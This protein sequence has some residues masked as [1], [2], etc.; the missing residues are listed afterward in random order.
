MS[1]A[2][3]NGTQTVINATTT[4]VTY[5]GTTTGAGTGGSVSPLKG[6][7]SFDNIQF[8]AT[9]GWIT[10]K[11]NGLI[12]SKIQQ[13]ANKTVLGNN[14]IVTNNVTAVSFTTVVDQ[15]GSVKKTQY[16]STGLLR[17]TN[18]AT[19]GYTSDSD[20]VMIE[21]TSGATGYSTGD[22]DKLMV[23]SSAGDFGGRTLTVQDLKLK[24][25]TDTVAVATLQRTTTA[26][27]GAHRVYN[28]NGSGGISLGSG[29]SGAGGVGLAA[30]HTTFYD[31]DYHSFRKRDGNTAAPITADSIQVTTITSGGPTTNASIIGRWSL[32]GVGSRM[33]ATYSADLAEYYEGDKTYEVGTVLIFGG[34]K[35][36]TIATTKEDYRIAGVVSDTAAYSMYGACPGEKNLIALQGRVPVRVAGKIKKGDLLVTSHIAGVA[37]SVGGTARTGTVIG[38]ALEDHD[39]DHVGTIQVA[40]G[41][42]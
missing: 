22:A 27:G 26:T 34:D 25:S 32:S 40:V 33:Q 1:I 7:A 29:T 14:D 16:S 13:I 24:L 23:R 35:E 12:L 39:S 38:K 4:T 9:N 28:F 18:A 21:A 10:V 37:V 17:R 20:Y 30:D 3:Y 41:R 31:N 11:D 6:L 5:S 15:G 36:V 42:T 19:G 2:G 8:T